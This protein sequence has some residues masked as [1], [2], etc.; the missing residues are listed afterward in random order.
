MPQRQPF[1][2]VAQFDF[3]N[4]L[5][6]SLGRF[7]TGQPTGN[8]IFN[9]GTVGFDVGH[10]GQ[11]LRLNGNNG[12][13]L[14]TGLIT[15]Y[16]Y[17]VSFWINPTAITRFTPGFFA[18]VNE[19]VDG[20]GFPFSTQWMSFLPESWDG[21]TML[22]SGSDQWFDGSAGLRIQPNAWRHLAFSVNKGVV[23]VYID[24]VRRFNAGTIADFFSTQAGIFA[25]GVNYW[26]LPFNG[27]IDELKF[28]EAALSAAEIRALDIDHLANPDL[29]ASAA[30]LL[31]LGDTS[32]VREDLRLPRSGAYASAVS[33]SSSNP[34]VLSDRGQVTRPGR[35][36]P[37]VDVTLTATL[38]L[39]GQITTRSFAVRV[40]SLA[41]PV[42]VAAYLFEDDLN[43]ASGSHAPG[44]THRQPRVPVRR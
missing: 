25:L 1:N 14:P 39:Q 4:S 11:A 15:N 8:R 12:V 24:G 23:S 36:Q 41:P 22:W 44:V 21:N 2:R 16:E 34:A 6:E 42:P 10:Q 30:A 40:K 9:A 43:E 18:A 38:T 37:D 29:L 31:D 7:G 17:T 19:R 35:D 26:D 13:R 27:M 32:A 28:Y 3:E 33:W 5:I 20:A